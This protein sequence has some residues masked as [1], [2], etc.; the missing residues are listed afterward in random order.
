MFLAYF[1]LAFAQTTISL[2]GDSTDWAPLPLNATALNKLQDYF[3]NE[4]GAII[5]DRVD[6]KDVKAVIQ[7]EV[8]YFFIRFG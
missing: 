7:G 8:F 5:S 3:P 1:G 6:V 2:D 4:V